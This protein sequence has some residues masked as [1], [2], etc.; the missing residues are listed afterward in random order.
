MTPYLWRH[1]RDVI[2]VTPQGADCCLCWAGGEIHNC[3]FHHTRRSQAF[4]PC[5][6]PSHAHVL[7][8]SDLSYWLDVQNEDNRFFKKN[9][10]KK[11]REMKI[12]YVH[13]ESWSTWF[14][15]LL[16]LL[17][18]FLLF[19]KYYLCVCVCVEGGGCLLVRIAFLISLASFSTMVIMVMLITTNVSNNIE[20]MI[21]PS[22]NTSNY[23]R[24]NLSNLRCG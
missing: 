15:L 5:P 2:A 1:R 22:I 17:L 21:H 20:Q 4:L 14:C 8:L 16:F 9:Q 7:R 13:V 11:K 10:K 19:F 23:I 18:L 3:T 6:V 24:W 12:K